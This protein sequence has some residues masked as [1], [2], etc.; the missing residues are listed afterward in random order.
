MALDLRG[1]VESPHVASEVVVPG[2]F[3]KL[4]RA[5]S[6]A[7]L[8]EGEPLPPLWHWLLFAP[9]TAP[10]ETGEEGHPLR[11]GFL[12]PLPHRRRMYAGGEVQFHAPLR[13]GVTATRRGEVVD[14]V[15][16]SG[17]T[18]DL[19]LVT[20][21]YEIT[22]AGEPAITE[23]QDLVFTDARP[24]PRTTFAPMAVPAAAYAGT[25]A[26]DEVM[27]FRFSALTFNSH[28]IHYDR[29]YATQ[30]EGYEDLVVHGPLTAIL[31][32]DLVRRNEPRT[33]A[34]FSFMSRA[35]L[36]VGEEI[37]LRADPTGSSIV[38]T[39]YRPEGTA[40]MSA[41]IVLR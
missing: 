14:I 36:Y 35:P 39:A 6:L 33:L 38:A 13:I 20:V 16:K 32:A 29:A 21:R 37:E 27:L 4:A 12:P 15:E 7:D 31:L 23:R 9:A 40:S 8:A 26:P 10:E 17:R 5:L 11:G 30:R 1:W 3:D 41:D 18:G 2:P 34:S 24:T 25:R 28:R 19:V 22:V